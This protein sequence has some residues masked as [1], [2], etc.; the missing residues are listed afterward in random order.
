MA[1]LTNSEPYYDQVSHAARP[2]TR[3]VT[4]TGTAISSTDGFAGI[5]VVSDA[6]FAS[7]SSA[8]TGF[9]GLANATAASASTIN[10]GIYLAG[11]CTAFSIHSGI[12]L[13]IGD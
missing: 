5:Y 9:S 12:V 4:T 13:G 1:D 8:V 10:A 3:Y 11:T 2:G 7:I 6:K